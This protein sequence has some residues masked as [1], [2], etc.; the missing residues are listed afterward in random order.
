MTQVLGIDPLDPAWGGRAAGSAERDVLDA[1]VTA[2]LAERDKARADRDFATA[3]AIRDELSTLGIV[4]EDT[5]AGAR[6]ALAP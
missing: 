1:L 2:R 6:W 3:D 4:V 5:P